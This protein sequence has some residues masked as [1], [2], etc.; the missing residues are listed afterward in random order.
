MT[1]TP[2]PSEQPEIKPSG[3]PIPPIEVEPDTG[4]DPT[5]PDGLWR[6]LPLSS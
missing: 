2:D 4:D 1:E 6:T 3:D 5:D